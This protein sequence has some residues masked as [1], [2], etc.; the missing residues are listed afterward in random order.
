MEDVAQRGVVGVQLD[1]SRTIEEHVIVANVPEAGLQ[2]LEILL[3]LLQ[4]VQHA[5][6]GAQLV[7]RHALL[8]RHEAADVKRARVA[9]A[10][11]GR[12]QI[13]DRTGASDGA[14]H[15]VHW[16]TGVSRESADMIEVGVRGGRGK[17][18]DGSKEKEDP[19]PSQYVLLPTP[20]LPRMSWPNGIATRPASL[21]AL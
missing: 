9:R 1:L 16:G 17:D 10:I 5:A 21:R 11:V 15:L 13:D 20:G 4:S 3:E 14:H 6:V 2:P 7:V 8:E 12:V 18:T 19:L